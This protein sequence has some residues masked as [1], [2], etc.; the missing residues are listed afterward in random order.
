M[1][2]NEKILYSPNEGIRLGSVVTDEKGNTVIRVK[3]GVNKKKYDN[4]C[5]LDIL[6]AMYGEDANYVIIRE[7]DHVITTIFAGD[8]KE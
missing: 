2:E 1:A 6:K 7:L 3:G 8:T 4:V 5:I